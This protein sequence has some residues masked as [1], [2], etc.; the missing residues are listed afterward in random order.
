MNVKIDWRDWNFTL[1]NHIDI[2]VVF[3]QSEVTS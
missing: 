3:W 2:E 1:Y